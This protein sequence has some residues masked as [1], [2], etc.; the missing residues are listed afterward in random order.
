M[1]PIAR[2]IS[3]AA[4]DGRKIHSN[5][6]IRADTSKCKSKSALIPILLTIL[7]LMFDR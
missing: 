3:P 1:I 7:L 6:Q 4:Q 2:V 5:K